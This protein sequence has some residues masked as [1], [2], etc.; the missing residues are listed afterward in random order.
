VTLLLEEL[1]REDAERAFA[2]GAMVVLPTG[3]IEQ[4]GPHLPVMTD[5]AIVTHVARA[6]AERASARVPGLVTPTMH[7]GVSHHHLDFAGALSVTSRVYV[8]A[9]KELARCLNRHGVRQLVLLNGHGGNEHPNGVIAHSLAHE[10]RLEMAIGR[11]SYWTLAAQAIV[12]AGAYDVAPSFPGHAGG[13]ETSAMLALRPDLVHLERRRPPTA[14]LASIEHAEEHGAWKR[15]GG[16]TDDA[17]RAS[18]EA[19]RR[20]LDA[21][22]GAVAEYL[23]QFYE[24]ARPVT[25][26]T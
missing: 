15:A 3:S 23:V 17:A 6:A 10:E 11:A 24:R 12:D 22:V 19:G 18:A 26:D 5:T 16:T 1:T 9:V 13:F 8:D 4:H 14:P 20:F 21:T 25:R 2:A 7:F